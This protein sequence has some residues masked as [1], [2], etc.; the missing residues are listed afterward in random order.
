MHRSQ[1]LGCYLSQML[2]ALLL[3]VACAAGRHAPWLQTRMGTGA[4]LLQIDAEANGSSRV[5]C[6]MHQA[7]VRAKLLISA[8]HVSQCLLQPMS[9]TYGK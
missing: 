5:K 1:S 7:E 6:E 9:F 8:S 2:Y 4:A 3:P